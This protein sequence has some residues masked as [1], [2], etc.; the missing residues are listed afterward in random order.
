LE[1]YT[2]ARPQDDDGLVFLG[3][4]YANNNELDKA[5]GAFEQALRVNPNSADAKNDLEIIRNQVESTE[6]K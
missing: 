5:I 6:K 3:E 1:K 2:V 4:A